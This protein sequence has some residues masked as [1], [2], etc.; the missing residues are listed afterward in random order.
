MDEPNC[1]II[2]ATEAGKIEPQRLTFYQA[3]VEQQRE[4]R[5]SH[6]EWKR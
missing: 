6:P 3:L 5:E 4:L 1:A 2:T